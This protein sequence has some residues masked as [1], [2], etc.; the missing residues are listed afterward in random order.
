MCFHF[1]YLLVT[2]ASKILYILNNYILTSGTVI[3]QI[4]LLCA[5]IDSFL[6]HDFGVTVLYCGK[7]QVFQIAFVITIKIIVLH[8]NQVL[9]FKFMFPPLF[10]NLSFL[11]LFFFNFTILYWF[12]HIST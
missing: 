10:F 2:K 8:E 9:K 5:N 4:C 6:Q 3:K 7:M 12:C 1:A 11:I